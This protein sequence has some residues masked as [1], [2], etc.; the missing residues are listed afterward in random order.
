MYTLALSFLIF[1]GT[2]FSLQAIV[3]E[4]ILRSFI[5]SNMAVFTTDNIG[6]DEFNIRKYMN[7]TMTNDPSLIRAYSFS[8][9]TM[10]TLP[11]CTL[12]RS[13]P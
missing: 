7:V 8:T 11:W 9:Y 13:K 4:D 5:G 10:N 1:A 3:I 6:L 2:G 12:R